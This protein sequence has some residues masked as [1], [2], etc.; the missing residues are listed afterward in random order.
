MKRDPYAWID[1]FEEIELAERRASAA[2]DAGQRRVMRG[3]SQLGGEALKDA[4]RAMSAAILRD[5]V[6]PYAKEHGDRMVN[7]IADR[8]MVGLDYDMASDTR[9]LSM[10]VVQPFRVAVSIEPDKWERLAL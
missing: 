2:Y 10:A 7:I 9:R 1:P 4:W 3:F 6:K 8:L 5:V